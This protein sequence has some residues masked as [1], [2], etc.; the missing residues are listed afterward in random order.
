M[1]LFLSVKLFVPVAL[2]DAELIGAMDLALGD[3]FDLGGVQRVALPACAF[4]GLAAPKVYDRPMNA[5]LV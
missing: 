1:T 5:A 4:D 3:A 2:D